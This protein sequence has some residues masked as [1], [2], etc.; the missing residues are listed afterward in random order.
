MWGTSLPRADHDGTKNAHPADTLPPHGRNAFRSVAV[1]SR[2]TTWRQHRPVTARPTAQEQDD[3]TA[4]WV[5]GSG[6]SL[7]GDVTGD[8]EVGQE[9]LAG[10]P[11]KPSVVA[12]VRHEQHDV[13]DTAITPLQRQPPLKDLRVAT[14]SLSLDPHSHVG[15]QDECVPGTTVARVGRQHLGPP[16]CM[17]AQARPQSVQEA[18]MCLIAQG[19]A[20]G[21]SAHMQVKPDDRERTGE[22]HDGEIRCGSAFEPTPGRC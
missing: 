2:W 15:Q 22:V 12:C 10:Q 17:R 18:E 11:E 7:E 5:L 9:T 21:V 13:V 4:T 20:A 1:V 19:L 14:A 8:R 3:G 6:K 16:P